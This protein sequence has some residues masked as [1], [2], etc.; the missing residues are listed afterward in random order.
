[1]STDNPPKLTPVKAHPLLEPIYAE[2][3]NLYHAGQI[4][5]EDFWSSS[6]AFKDN[7]PRGVE[8]WW[9]HSCR[10]RQPDIRK[11]RGIEI[12]W[13]HVNFYGPSGKR[14]PISNYIARGNERHAYR[15]SAFHRAGKEELDAILKAEDVF[16]MIR[17]RAEHLHKARRSIMAYL[18]LD[19]AEAFTEIESSTTKKE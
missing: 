8:I 4:A 16:A 7:H 11:A 1:M 18:K 13:A 3:D 2:L 12:T 6:N 5:L 10:I 9:S 19:Q 17:Q 14:K 15:K